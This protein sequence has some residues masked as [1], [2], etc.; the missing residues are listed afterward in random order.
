MKSFSMPRPQTHCPG[1]K[2]GAKPRQNQKRIISSHSVNAESF[3]V[4]IKT[5]Q[6]SGQTCEKSEN[7]LDLEGLR[8]CSS[9]E[10]TI[11]LSPS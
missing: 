9:H 10:I 2:R 4:S 11:T 7:I 5:L 6:V 3:L 1:R 8:Y